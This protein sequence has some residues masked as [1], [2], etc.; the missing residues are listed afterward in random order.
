MKVVIDIPED[1]YEQTINGTEF[2]TL[3]LGIKLKQS[4]QKWVVIPKGHGRLIDADVLENKFLEMGCIDDK[5]CYGAEIVKRIR[6]IIEADSEV[7]E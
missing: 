6:P 1:I 4:V 2:D 7:E 3:S 5:P